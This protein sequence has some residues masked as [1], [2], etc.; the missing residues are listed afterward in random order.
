MQDKMIVFVSISVTG[1]ELQNGDMI[2]LKSFQGKTN[3]CLVTDV[4]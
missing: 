4:L 2:S 1:I 3:Q